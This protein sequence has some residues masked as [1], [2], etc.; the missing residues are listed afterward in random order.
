MKKQNIAETY[1]TIGL[2]FLFGFS[3]TSF[4]K[5]NE[6]IIAEASTVIIQE[7]FARYKPK[8]RSGEGE[9]VEERKILNRI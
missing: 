9:L 1:R 3:F 5:H 7:I 2:N 4:F 8:F 6:S